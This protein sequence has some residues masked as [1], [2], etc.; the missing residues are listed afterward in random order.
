MILNLFECGLMDLFSSSNTPIIYPPEPINVYLNDQ[1]DSSCIYS[2]KDSV[3]CFHSNGYAPLQ[4]GNS[5]DYYDYSYSWDGN[6]VYAASC[7]I[8]VN[9]VQILNG[10]Y[11]FRTSVLK[12]GRDSILSTFIDSNT[13]IPSTM[14]LLL[15]VFSADTSSIQPQIKMDD[16]SYCFHYVDTPTI[17]YQTV[18]QT[19]AIFKSGIGLIYKAFG[20]TSVYNAPM[21][22]GGYYYILLKFNNVTFDFCDFIHEFQAKETYLTNPLSRQ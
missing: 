11:V 13:L 12:R 19:D 6:D 15:P 9:L 20:V 10:N 8:S 3:K 2:I 17:P 1:N 22:G 4:V 16:G 14:P 18:Y 7:T 21:G 5:W